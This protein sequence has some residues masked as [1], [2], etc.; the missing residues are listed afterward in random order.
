MSRCRLST[1]IAWIFVDLDPGNF[2]LFAVL[3]ERADGSPTGA[4]CT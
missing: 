4:E 1:A 2:S 3:D